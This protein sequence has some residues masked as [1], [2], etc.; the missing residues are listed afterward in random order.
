MLLEKYHLKE[1]KEEE[2]ER[3]AEEIITRLLSYPSHDFVIDYNEAKEIGLNVELLSG[4]D[5]DKIL[6]LY[7]QYRGRLNNIVLIIESSVT[8]REIK[9]EK[10]TIW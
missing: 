5:K 10:I 7:M 8:K 1:E 6:E 9:R 2:K 4:E 3:E